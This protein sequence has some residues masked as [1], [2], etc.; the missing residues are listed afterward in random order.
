MKK[1]I[2]FIPIILFYS[3]RSGKEQKGGQHTIT[4]YD[5]KVEFL[6]GLKKSFTTIPIKDYKNVSFKAYDL[7]FADSYGD[8]LKKINAL[9]KPEDDEFFSSQINEYEILEKENVEI[10]FQL[11]GFNYISSS[12]LKSLGTTYDEL[13]SNFRKKYGEKSVLILSKPLLSKDLK[14]ALIEIQGIS[15]AGK[16]ANMALYA[17]KK[18]DNR[19][20]LLSEL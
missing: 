2:L 1:L 19:W 8:I 13:W 7:R 10:N 14:I 16:S 15:E 4:A 11:K 9:L 17:F 6:N 20:S 3:C 18:T 5:A 12:E